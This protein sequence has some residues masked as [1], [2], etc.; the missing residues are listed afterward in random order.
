M[1]SARAPQ[2]RRRAPGRRRRRPA[3]RPAPRGRDVGVGPGRS[4][5]RHHLAPP[6]GHPLRVR[7]RLLTVA[8]AATTVCPSASTGATSAA[9][10]RS[11]A[12][13]SSEFA[14]SAQAWWRRQGKP[15]PA[16][17]GTRGRHPAAA[18]PTAPISWRSTRRSAAWTIPVRSAWGS[19]SSSAA[20]PSTTWWPTAP[21]S[22]SRRGLADQAAAWP[23][24]RDR[25]HRAHPGAVQRRD[26]SHADPLRQCREH[27]RDRLQRRPPARLGVQAPPAHWDDL[28]DPIYAGSDRPGRSHQERIQRQG[29]RDDHPAEDARGGH[30]LPA[31]T[32][33]PSRASK[34]RSTPTPSG[35]AGAT[36]AARCPRACRPPTRPRSSGAGSTA[37]CSS[38]ASAP[39]RATSP[40][41]RARWPSTSPWATRP[42]AWPSTST[43]ATRRR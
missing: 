31:S 33:R 43:R 30:W 34:G 39:T 23:A 4:R 15:W 37:C 1:T 41:P 11:S 17:A 2:P 21:A 32:W 24:H 13:S 29:L 9:P 5:A 36:G 35:W 42:S 40:T 22:A 19:I 38:S 8:P 6:R 3:L 26:L 27:V 25:R 18:A 16:G 14:A 10:P 28:A 7:A 20:A 12:I